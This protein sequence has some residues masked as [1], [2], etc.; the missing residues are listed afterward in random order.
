MC[1]K[2]PKA[3]RQAVQPTPAGVPAAPMESPV[4]QE[5]GAARRAENEALYGSARGPRLR[6]LANTNKSGT[7]APS[8]AAGIRM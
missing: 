7:A 1:P 4:Q 6:R 5:V 3:P 8:G 2:R